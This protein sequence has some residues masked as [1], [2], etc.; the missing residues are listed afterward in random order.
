MV[1]VNVVVNFP[2][3]EIKIVLRCSDLVTN[4][5]NVHSLCIVFSHTNKTSI[6]LWAHVSTVRTGIGDKGV[7][8]PVRFVKALSSTLKRQQRFVFKDGETTAY[9]LLSLRW[10]I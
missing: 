10:R 9:A 6:V 7:T 4:G 1:P 3:G 5:T 2:L 8:A